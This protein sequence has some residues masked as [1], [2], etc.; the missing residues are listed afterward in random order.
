MANNGFILLIAGAIQDE[1]RLQQRVLRR[2]LRDHHD[3]LDMPE[4]QFRGI[5]RMSRD[6]VHDLVIELAPHMADGVREAIFIPKKTK[7]LVALHFYSQGSYQKAVGQDYFLPMSQASVSRSIASVNLGLENLYYKIHFPVT[8]EEKL[9][10]KRGFLDMNNGFPGIIGA[11]DGT[12]IAIRAP[13]V[14]DENFPA[15]VFYNRKG[16]YSLNVQ[17]ICDSKMKILAVNARFPGSVHDAG[18]WATSQ[19]R[20][21]LQNSYIGGDHSSWLIVFI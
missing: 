20:Q 2:Y 16:F 6:L 10:V 12:Q 11:I 19:I 5:Y 17:I 3:A 4:E 9:G 8:D 14:N 13:P 7:I 21:L 1:E 18:I 15:I